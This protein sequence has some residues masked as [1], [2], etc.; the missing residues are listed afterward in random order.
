MRAL[1]RNPQGKKLQM[2]AFFGQGAATQ[3][4]TVRIS[5][6]PPAKSASINSINDEAMDDEEDLTDIDAEFESLLNKTFEMES[7]RLAQR[8]EPQHGRRH[9]EKVGSA[10]AA[11]TGDR[12]TSLGGDHSLRRSSS[13]G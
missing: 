8:E 6:K 5:E 10:V 7:R 11:R 12:G 4:K 3:Q 1:S 9:E 2:M 13:Y